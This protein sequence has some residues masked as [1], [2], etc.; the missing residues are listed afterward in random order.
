MLITDSAGKYMQVAKTSMGLISVHIEIC[1]AHS[2]A[3]HFWWT[4]NA[5]ATAFDTVQLNVDHM[6]RSAQRTGTVTHR[7]Y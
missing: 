3:Y 1:V 4:H 5:S 6:Y 2:L 7:V